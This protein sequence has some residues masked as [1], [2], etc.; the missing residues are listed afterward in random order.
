MAA[1]CPLLAVPSPWAVFGAMAVFGVSLPWFFVGVATIRQKNTPNELIG[2]VSGASSLAVQAPQAIG[3]LAGAGLVLALSYR[4]LTYLIA[5]AIALTALYLGTRTTHGDF[6][7]P[8]VI[9]GANAI[10]GKQA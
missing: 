9:G 5:A 8:D 4:D 1:S 10:D 6:G 7:F 3:N 2:R